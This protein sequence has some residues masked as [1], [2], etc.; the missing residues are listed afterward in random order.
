MLAQVG[1][2]VLSAALH[3]FGLGVALVAVQSSS[4]L[5]QQF[6]KDMCDLT[7]ISPCQLLCQT[8]VAWIQS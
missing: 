3:L 1:A 2:R 8:Q 4:C 6:V 7:A 5:G